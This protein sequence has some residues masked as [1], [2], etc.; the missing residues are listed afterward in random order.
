MLQEIG[1]TKLKLLNI[2]YNKLSQIHFQGFEG[3][4]KLKTLDLSYNTLK[5]F[6]EN[7]WVSMNNLEELFLAG[8][9]LRGINAEPRLKLKKLKVDIQFVYD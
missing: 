2:S 8:N 5:Y 6:L 7:W 4:S 1:L 9:L 3:L